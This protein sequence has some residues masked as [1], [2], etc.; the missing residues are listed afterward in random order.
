MRDYVDHQIAFLSS[1]AHNPIMGFLLAAASAFFGGMLGQF[2]G[3]ATTL[4]LVLV[5]LA[6]FLNTASE[7]LIC[8]RSWYYGKNTKWWASTLTFAHIKLFIW[9]TLLFISFVVKKNILLLGLPALA[10]PPLQF[11]LCGMELMLF[12]V[13]IGSAFKHVGTF[14]GIKAFRRVGYGVE[15]FRDK[16]VDKALDK[17]EELSK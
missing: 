6:W 12:L 17:A 4:P 9:A 15:N 3:F 11:C 8:G 13:E 5:F 7:M 14:T 16:M 2:E 1:E 10:I